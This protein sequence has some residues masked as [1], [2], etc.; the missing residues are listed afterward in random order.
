MSLQE[1]EKTNEPIIDVEVAYSKTEQFIEDNKNRLALVAIIL[2]VLFGGYFA[3]KYLYIQPMDEEAQK[4]MWK[5]E[6]YFEKDSFDLALNGDG[7]YF[8]F[9]QIIS[10]YG[11]SKT[12][13]LAQYYSGI[14]YLR[15]GEFENAIEYLEDFDSDDEMLAP[16][17]AGAIGDAYMEL[18]KTDEAVSHYVSAAEMEDNQFTAPVYLMKAGL[19]FELQNDFSGAKKVY[20]KI[21]KDYPETMEGKNV[22][23]YLAR[24]ESY[25]K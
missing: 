8:G 23:K 15:K 1:S 2:T 22:D 3:Y 20:Q 6:Q 12:A 11:L 16:I 5:A 9:L 10:D 19:A 21:K 24:A 25:V 14:C 13:N 17:A 7:N 4:Q 18:G